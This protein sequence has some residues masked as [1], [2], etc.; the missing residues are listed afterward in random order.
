VIRGA[1]RKRRPSRHD[2]GQSGCA[3]LLQDA[4]ELSKWSIQ[5]ARRGVNFVGYRTWRRTRVI[6]KYSLHKFA[7]RVRRGDDAAIRSLLAHA[8]G[9]ASHRRMIQRVQA[10]RPDLAAALPQTL[11]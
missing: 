4:L 8:K 9:T 3:D 5:P 11:R 2:K 6:R 1:A 10:D 7:A